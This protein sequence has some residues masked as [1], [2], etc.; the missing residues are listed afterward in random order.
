MF[1]RVPD[2]YENWKSA[3]VQS[4]QGSCT[5][6]SPVTYLSPGWDMRG[7]EADIKFIV[8]RYL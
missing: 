6:R 4:R 2:I 5:L 3:N 7:A 1:H 8:T